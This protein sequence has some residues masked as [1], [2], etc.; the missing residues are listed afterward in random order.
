MLKTDR[1]VGPVCL[2]F[3]ELG[4]PT[5]MPK[6]HDRMVQGTSPAFKH[7]PADVFECPARHGDRPG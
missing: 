2:K 6:P 7:A 3:A 4:E 5:F 1:D